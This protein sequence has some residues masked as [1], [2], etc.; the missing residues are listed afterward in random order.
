MKLLS[1]LLIFISASVYAE[2]DCVFD[3][4]SY[5]EFIQKYSTGHRD[6]KIGPDG[7]TLVIERNDEEIL[8]EGG[9]CIHLGMAIKLSTQQAYTE[10]QLLQKALDLS[11]EFG[12]W[13]INTQALRDSITKG[14][15]E[16]IDGSYYIEVDAMTVFSTTYGNQGKIYVDFYIN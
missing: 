7:K 16:K 14:D 11:I 10:A 13:L 12:S 3:E 15:Y 1:I 2:D 4:T 5:L 9:G 8:V 6:S